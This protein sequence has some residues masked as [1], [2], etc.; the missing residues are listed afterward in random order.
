MAINGEWLT[1]NDAAK[2]SGYHPESIRELIR[3]GKIKARKFSIVYQ[4]SRESLLEYI[5]KAKEIGE[6][7]GRKP[8]K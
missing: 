3:Q 7:R 6:K 2:L 1:V 8:G 4:V 5:A